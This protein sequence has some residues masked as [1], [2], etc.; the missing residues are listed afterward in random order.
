MEDMSALVAAQAPDSS[1]ITGIQGRRLAPL[2]VLCSV[3]LVDVMGA[4]SMLAAAPS[5]GR[6]LR[7][8]AAE[9]QWS[10]TAAT[11]TGTALLMVGALLTD[12]IGRRP[13]VIVGLAGVMLSWVACPMVCRCG[14][15]AI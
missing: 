7:L 6:A 12:R 3:F 5:L 15:S 13:M 9:L 11:L 8:G 10:L 1:P 2:L 4:A 14:R